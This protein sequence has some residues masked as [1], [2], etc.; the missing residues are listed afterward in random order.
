M[1]TQL[2]VSH[3]GQFI[4]LT[5]EEI[6]FLNRVLIRRPF[7]A[8][9]IIVQRGEPARYL[10][11][12]NAGYT[13][14]Y[15]TD[16]NADEHVIRFAAPGWWSGDIYS[17]SQEPNTPLTTKGLCEGE[18]LLLPRLAHSQLLEQYPKFERYFRILFQTALMRQQLRF[19][20]SHSIPAD[21]RYAKF[22]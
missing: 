12:V 3:M 17:L 11:Y 18:L 10:A 20:E 16:P 15:Y 7:T 8:N 9:E 4:D 21:Q 14:T 1:N 6:D 22:Q 5:Q 13:V 19:V 2:L